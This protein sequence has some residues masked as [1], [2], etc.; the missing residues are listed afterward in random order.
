LPCGFHYRFGSAA[1]DRLRH[2]D[3]G[4]E[5]DFHAR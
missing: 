3:I 5:K 2:V 4:V 1:Q